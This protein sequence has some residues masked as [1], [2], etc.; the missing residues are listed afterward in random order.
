MYSFAN[1]ASVDASG[2]YLISIDIPSLF[3]GAL[4]GGFLWA[5]WETSGVTRRLE[6]LKRLFPAVLCF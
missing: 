6:V 3:N 4:P 2:T 1:D 5:I